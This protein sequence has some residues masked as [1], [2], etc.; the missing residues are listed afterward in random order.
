[1]DLS[2][3]SPRLAVT[4]GEWYASETI[5]TIRIDLRQRNGFTRI[6][7]ALCDCWTVG[8]CPQLDSAAVDCGAVGLDDLI[9]RRTSFPPNDYSAGC[10]QTYTED[11]SIVRGFPHL[12]SAVDAAAADCGTVELVDLIVRRM[13]FPPDDLSAGRDGDYIWKDLWTSSSA[14]HEVEAPFHSPLCHHSVGPAG[15]NVGG[16]RSP[17]VAC[18]ASDHW[19]A[20]SNPLRGMFR[21]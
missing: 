9:F 1:M 19:V 20:S 4:P 16:R 21:H 5:W 6:I 10:D 17:A 8:C 15:G 3:D 14:S 13:S 2:T 7:G 11:Y 12:E 18:W